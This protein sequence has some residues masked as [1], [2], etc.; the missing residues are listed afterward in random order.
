[1]GTFTG[2]RFGRRRFLHGASM[3][4]AGTLLP[5]H[6]I[7]HGASHTPD[8]RQRLSTF[9]CDITVPLG[10]PIYSS[11]EPLDTIEHPLLAKGVVIE[12]GD[13]RY[14]LCAVDWCY[15]C[16]STYDAFRH[17]VADAADTDVAHVAVQNVHQHTAPMGDADVWPFLRELES[18]PPFPSPEVFTSAAATVGEAVRQS[19][20]NLTP[21][22]AIGTSQARVDRVASNRRIPVGEGR[23]GF[24]ASACRDEEMRAMPEG[25]IDPMLQTITF[26]Q[27]ERPLARL[28]YYAT[29]P[30]SFYGD[31]RASYDFP[32]MARERLEQEEGVFQVYFTG[33]AGDVAAGK[34]N[35]GTPEARQGLYERLYAAMKASSAATRFGPA[36]AIEW[37]TAEFP[38]TTRED[39]G[40]TEADLRARMDNAGQRAS[41]RSGAA[42]GLAYRARVAQPVEVS[43]MHV[44][45]V[46]IVHLPG[47]PM[48]EFQLFAKQLR[49]DGFVAVAGFGD[50]AM[51]YICPARA[52]DEGGYEPTA[53]KLRP[54]SEG[55][56]RDAIRELLRV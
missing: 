22:D 55:P 38:L 4:T 20:A 28:H 11:Y 53:S 39:E 41:T 36:Q 35:D 46:H 34:Y 51:G 50:C 48:I 16:N 27:G 31:P 43:A 44:G 21:F 29:H 9:V 10:T 25:L 7:V 32:G 40:Y 17:A 54:E 42:M 19:V 23:V 18:P 52:Y 14:V 3:L 24:R 56:F 1:M 45:N 6:R 5:G 12:Q 8:T 49:Q 30:Q 13:T 33:C 26:A 15:L 47:E 37:T 2:R